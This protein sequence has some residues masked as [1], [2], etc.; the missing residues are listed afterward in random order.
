VPAFHGRR[1]V[2][3]LRWDSAKKTFAFNEKYSWQNAGLEQTDDHPV[4]NVTWNDAVTFCKWVSKKVGKTFR[5][6]TE[7]EWEY[8]CRAGTTMRYYELAISDWAGPG[9][10]SDLCS[11][12]APGGRRTR[13]GKS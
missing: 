12:T 4:V 9:L 6:P 7:A 10:W 3:C 13:I 2:R 11:F 1:S 5:L 8:A